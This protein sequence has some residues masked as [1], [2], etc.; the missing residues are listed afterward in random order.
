MTFAAQSLSQKQPHN[1]YGLDRLFFFINFLA[2]VWFLFFLITDKLDRGLLC[3]L[4]STVTPTQHP[5]Q[6]NDTLKTSGSLYASGKGAPLRV[7]MVL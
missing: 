5:C 2:I 6:Y 1:H 3:A 4:N 7:R